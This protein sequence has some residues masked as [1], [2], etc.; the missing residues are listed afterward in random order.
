MGR[1]REEFDAAGKAA[2]FEY[3][4]AFLAADRETM[5]YADIAKNTGMSEGAARVAVHRLRHRFR[6][7]FREEISHTVA[8][9]EE[10]EG[11]VRYLLS[12]LAA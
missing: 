11:E 3:L 1:L 10:V 2:E 7:I 6:D 4:K 9:P 12:V 8:G 5:S